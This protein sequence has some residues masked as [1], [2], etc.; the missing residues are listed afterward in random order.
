MS[1]TR[2]VKKGDPIRLADDNAEVVVRKIFTRMGERLEVSAGD[3]WVRPDAIMLESLS[4][5]DVDDLGVEATGSEA[6][7]ADASP[8]G[9][10]DPITISSEFAQAVVRPFGSEAGPRL[11]IEAPKMGYEIELEP[12]HLAWLTTLGHETFSEWLETPFGPGGDDH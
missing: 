1:P 11:G 3:R 12:R 4:W 6:S 2:T 10:R 7:A 8:P 5:Q 9:D